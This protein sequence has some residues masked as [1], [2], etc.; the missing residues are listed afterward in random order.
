MSGQFVLE[1]M[2]LSMDHAAIVTETGAASH[3]GLL[4]RAEAWRERFAAEGLAPGAVVSVEGDYRVESVAAFLGLMA[5]GAVI[6]PMA[7][8]DEE[9]RARLLSIAQVEWR[10]QLA[11]SQDVTR[12]QVAATHPHYAQLRAGG[13]AG[14]VLFS[15][16]STGASK[17]IVHDLEALLA[18]FQIAR[19]RMCTL[20]FLLFDHIG[21]INTLFHTLANGGTV[22]VAGARSPDR[23]CE[24]IAQH[25]V[26]LLPTSPSFLNLLLV[27]GA[28]ERHDLRSLK[29]VTYGTEPMPEATLARAR[30]AMPWVDFQ[31]TYGLTEIGIL[32]SKS[33]SDG[34]LWV[35]LGGEGYETKIKDQRLWVRAA[36]AMLG[37]LNAPSP[38]DA[39]GFLDTGDLVETEGEWLRIL[40][41][42]DDRINVG[43]EKVHP[44]EV[45][46]VL[47]QMPNVVDAVVYGQPHPLIGQIVVAS[48]SLAAP[49]QPSA[50]K[51]RVRAFCG[52]RLPGYKVPLK[53]TVADSLH[54]GRF[55]RMR[56][57]QH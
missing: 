27:S 20:L 44:T 37:Y 17:G 22:V 24:A 21:G 45:E 38:F 26:E 5:H 50:V 47:L 34:S 19:R 52:S 42:Q 49:E 9:Q 3:A 48:L 16:G 30:E 15:S 57:P 28:C 36:S 7:V 6:V 40:G 8:G 31:Q 56:R 12:T 43:G 51:A 41:R 23:V 10:V 29:L 14:L 46:N 32:R 54:S 55:K 2:R 35:K 1:R 33:R 18:K 25:G 11:G 13:A 53:V 39:E 4:A